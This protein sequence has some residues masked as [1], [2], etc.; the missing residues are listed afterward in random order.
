M[1]QFARRY[2]RNYGAVAGLAI[3]LAVVIV[4]LAA[5]L[6]YEDSPWMMV[7]DPLIP[8]F[9]DA[10]YPSAPTCWAATSPPAW[11]GARGSR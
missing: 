9:T 5:P 3:V 10:A 11:C 8:P 2:M 6:L 1:K 4:A 7:A